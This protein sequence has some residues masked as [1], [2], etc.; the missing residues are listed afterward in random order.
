MNKIILIGNLTRDPELRS[1]NTMNGPVN[2]CSFTIAVN[3]RGNRN[4]Q[5]QNGQ[6]GDAD[7]FRI[8]VWRQQA[9][10]C[11]KYLAKG[12]KVFVSGPLSASTYQAQDGSTRVSLEVTA[13]EVEFLSSRND[14]QAAGGYQQ[15]GYSAP[16]APA[17]MAQNSGFT[18][19]ET[20]ELPF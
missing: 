10:N 19:V 1:V 18:A 3:R 20:D 14:D 4:Q 15:G 7:F 8:T 5:Q 2:V 16:A 6:Q 11:A 17:P 13:D 9:D 12:R